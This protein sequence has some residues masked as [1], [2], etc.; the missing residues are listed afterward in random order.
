MSYNDLDKFSLSTH[1]HTWN[2]ISGKPNTFTPSSH[3][4]NDLYYTETEVNNLL[5]QYSKSTHNHNTLY[6]PIDQIVY[7]S[8]DPGDG[9]SVSLSDNTLICVYEG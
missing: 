3:N 6:A 8:T 5:T 4:H 2:D 9:T 7:T 1:T